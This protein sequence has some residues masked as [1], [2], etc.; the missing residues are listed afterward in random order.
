MDDHEKNKSIDYIL[1]QGL[2]RPQKMRERI[3]DMTQT[4]GLRF[5]FWDTGYSLFFSAVTLTLV[6]VLSI[7]APD[8]YRHSFAVAAA[9]LVFLLLGA[10]TETA[11]RASG[12]YE[13]K[14][15]CR[16]TVQQ[17][18]ALRVIF[19]SVAG[20]A[21]TAA[22]TAV[23]ANDAYEFLSLFPLCLSALSVCSVLFLYVTRYLVGKW[24]GMVYSAVW[25]FMSI[26]LPFSF[27]ES[28]ETLLGA[29]PIALSVAITVLGAVALAY[30]IK[31]MLSE[32]EHYAVA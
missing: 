21:F 6:L 31:K 26:A 30:Q 29:V 15:T 23:S 11:E 2:V 19:Y 20:V 7:V 1:S 12:L 5:I 10:F 9:P 16:Y 8:E 14:Q 28:W 27:R 18:A 32:V 22:I 24:G 13:L 4:L 17:V 25:V 3:S